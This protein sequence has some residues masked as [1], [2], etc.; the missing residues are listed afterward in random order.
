MSGIDGGTVGLLSLT[1]TL[2]VHLIA[3]VW[4]AA[5]ITKRVEHVEKWITSNAQTAER[6]AGL[7][8][9]IENMIGGIDRIEHILRGLH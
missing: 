5:T 1:V 2:S 8:Q 7:E 3:T 9:Q 6:L 4:W